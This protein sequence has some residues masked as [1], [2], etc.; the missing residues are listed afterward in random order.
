MAQQRSSDRTFWILMAVLVVGAVLGAFLYVLLRHVGAGWVAGLG[1]VL[2]AGVVSALV[3]R[4]GGSAGPGPV[5]AAPAAA[6]P[7]ATPTVAEPAPAASP[8]AAEPAPAASPAVADPAPA[9]PAPS[10]PVAPTVDVAPAAPAPPDAEAPAG[11]HAYVASA[12]VT[13]AAQAAREALGDVV[14]EPAGA[15]SARPTAL[16]APGEGGPD[17]LKR[18]RG[19]G[20]KLEALLHSLGYFH[21]AQ[22]AAW[23]PEEI[24]WVDK[25]LEGF[26]GR[27]T[28]DDWVGQAK[29]L[30][31]GGETEHSRR[32]DS[33]E[34][35]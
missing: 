18:I 17:D 29:L 14:S 6:A 21:F 1:I 22:I 35:G 12:A 15:A 8:T 19:V 33:G 5:V 11:K 10:E 28:R 4:Q 27:A 26:N 24:A 3:L 13:S 23:G 34:A 16:D 25:N 20:P 2:L 7:V 31:A 32:V 9:A 30:A